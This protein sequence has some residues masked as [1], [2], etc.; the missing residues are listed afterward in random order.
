M[1][2][3]KIFIAID[4]PAASGK[5]TI[6]DLLA[7][8]LKLPVLH[9]G[10]IYRAIGCK[11]IENSISPENQKE[12]VKFAEELQLK[13]LKN[14]K[15]A[16][17]IVGNYASK[18]AIYSELRQATHKFQRSFIENAEK[19]AIIEGR[20]IGT[21]ICP[22]ATYKFYIT[23]DVE[24]RAKRRSLQNL[25]IDYNI[26]LN[27]L[28][29]RDERDSSRQAAPLKPAEDAIIIDSSSLSIIE[30]IDRIEAIILGKN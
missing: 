7:E 12:A 10:N 20:D 30:V 26:I 15:L 18:I 22:E 8:K 28:K 29:I 3:K 14:D 21:V 19:G 9:T 25:N 11:L 2:E 13:D 23:A 16:E 24:I 6:A 4:G 5:G 1:E 27:D 17:E